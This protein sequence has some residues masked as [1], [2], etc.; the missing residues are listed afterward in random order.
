VRAAIGVRGGSFRGKWHFAAAGAAV[1]E[2]FGSRQVDDLRHLLA[3]SIGDSPDRGPQLVTSLVR[4]LAQAAP[5]STTRYTSWMPAPRS[6]SRQ[7][8]GSRKKSIQA[9]Q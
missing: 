6:M 5:S 3:A 2:P 9:S 4:K 1:L 7:S 8:T